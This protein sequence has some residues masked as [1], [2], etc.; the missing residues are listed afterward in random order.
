MKKP[1]RPTPLPKLTLEF[2]L[3][4]VL[5]KHCGERGHNEGAVDTLCRIIAERDIA[6]TLLALD[7]IN[8]TP[9]QRVQRWEVSWK[10]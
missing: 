3:C 1:K 6:L 2:Q 8:G 5:C 10:E 9:V 4:E 7:R